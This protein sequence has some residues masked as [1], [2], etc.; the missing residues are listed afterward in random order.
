MSTK[1]IAKIDTHTIRIPMLQMADFSSLGAASVTIYHKPENPNLYLARVWDMEKF[2]PT[3][4]C[5]QRSSLKEIRADIQ[6][7][8]FYTKIPRDPEDDPII[9]ENWI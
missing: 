6:A 5:V 9:V 1:I 8:G 2:L 3:N 7:A 4:I